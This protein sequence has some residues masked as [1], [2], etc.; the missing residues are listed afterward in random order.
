MEI[1]YKQYIS[2]ESEVQDLMILLV[3][4]N[5]LIRCEIH[6]LFSYS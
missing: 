1:G 5:G 6:M 4:L 3:V 2:F